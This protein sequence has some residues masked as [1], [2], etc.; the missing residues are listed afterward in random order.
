MA[1]IVVIDAGPLW[2]AA[3]VHALTQPGNVVAIAT[4]NVRH[5]GRFPGIAAHSWETIT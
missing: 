3:G 1:R 5:L 4:T 2:L